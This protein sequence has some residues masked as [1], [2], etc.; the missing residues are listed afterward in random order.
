MSM[1]KTSHRRRRWFWSL[2]VLALAA[3]LAPS[4]ALA[5]D[6]LDSGDTAWMLTATAL[7]LFM[8]IPGLSL[9]YGGL[10]RA[11]N[12]LSVLMQGF[13][14]TAVMTLVWIMW[15]YSLAFDTTGMEAGT[16]NLSSFVGGLGK[17][18]LA[19]VG[20]DSM[21]GTV[22]ET[23]FITFQMTF[24]II[25]PALIAGAFAER[26]KFSAMLLFMVLWSS[27][28][29]API[30]HMTWSGAGAYFFDMVVIFNT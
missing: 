9:F 17:A 8:T 15:G 12:V 14:L 26:M 13:A 16:V 2:P 24:A 21:V 3:I 19:G 10:V 5:S 4:G 11:K 22:P 29:Y 28:V 7:V 30:C 23:V 27:F 20:V 1:T 18:L 25:T 6:G